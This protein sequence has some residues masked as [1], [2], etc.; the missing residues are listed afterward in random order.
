MTQQSELNTQEPDTARRRARGSAKPFPITKFEDVLLLARTIV[1]EAVDDQ[2]RRLTL[3]ERLD[4]SPSSGTSRQLTISSNRYGLTS[5]GYNADYIRVTEDG[6]EIAGQETI[7]GRTLPT[8]F[9]CAIGQFD[10]FNQLYEKLKNRRLPAKDLLQD[11]FV[12]M[13]LEPAD[14]EVAAEVFV[15][16][17]KHIG[18][19]RVVSG[20][21]HLIPIE[22][23]LEEF[24]GGEDSSDDRVTVGPAT[25]SEDEGQDQDAGTAPTTSPTLNEPSIHIDVQIHI[26]ST[27]TPEQIDQIFASM[28][29]H[30]Y[31]REV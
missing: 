31:I 11:E 19:I 10:I 14:C 28:A 9:K 6:K 23:V 3:F 24:E 2:M 8:A 5:G 7:T 18:I 21:E 1:E 17:A 25:D 27:A 4:R 20:S 12:Q 15:A 16:N 30:L 13:E 29:R 22:H 26:D